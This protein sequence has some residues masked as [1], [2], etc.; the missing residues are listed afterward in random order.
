MDWT[1]AKNIL[2]A[3]L[4]LTNL[5]LLGNMLY[6]NA[7]VQAKEKLFIEN[8]LA[9]LEARNITIETPLPK[10]QPRMP[11]L[12]VEYDNDDAAVIQEQIANQQALPKSQWI[13]ADIRTMAEKLLE[14]CGLLTEN[15]RYDGFQMKNG[16]FILTYSDVIKGI[17]I[18]DSYMTCVVKDGKVESINRLWLRPVDFGKTKKQVIPL[19][20]ALISFMSDKTGS[21][22]IT[23]N[24]IELV[25]WLDTGSV[26][27][28]TPI[29]DTAFPA[30]KISFNNGQVAH[31]NAFEQ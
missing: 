22:K 21:E 9:V 4:L 25:Y 30:W 12:S 5:L 24:K 15:V 8:T 26:G 14:A 10:G 31:I 23:I 28:E 18:E 1:K 16:S 7:N 20:Q 3:A 19:A 27:L 6:D 11:V 17:A 13:E 29:S 2:I